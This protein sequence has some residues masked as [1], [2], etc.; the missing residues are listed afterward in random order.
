[1]SELFRKYTVDS[2]CLSAWL[3]KS[4]WKVF[5]RISYKMGSFCMAFSW[6]ITN[7]TL[8]LLAKEKTAHS[9]QKACFWY[10]FT[11]FSHWNPFHYIFKEDSEC[12]LCV[13]WMRISVTQ[14]MLRAR[15]GLRWQTSPGL[16]L[17]FELLFCLR[18]IFISFQEIYVCICAETVP[19]RCV[20]SCCKVSLCVASPA[21]LE[22]LCSCSAAPLPHSPLFLSDLTP[23]AVPPHVTSPIGS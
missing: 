23:D 18:Q 21:A 11:C 4:P 17:F 8:G 1:M 12:Q 14:W 13:V 10:T 5:L 19:V 7:S 16:C 20:C 22:T 15:C 3:L 9:I 2:C 6:T